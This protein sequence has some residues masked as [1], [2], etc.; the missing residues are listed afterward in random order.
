MSAPKPDYK[1]G[2][3]QVRQIRDAAEIKRVLDLA[4]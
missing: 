3:I 4:K 2:E 1:H